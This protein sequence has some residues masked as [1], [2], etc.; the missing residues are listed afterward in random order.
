MKQNFKICADKDIRLVPYSPVQERDIVEIRCQVYN[1]SCKTDSVELI[2]CFDGLEIHKQTLEVQANSYGLAVF[3]MPMTGKAGKHQI[4]INGES[5]DLEVLKAAPALL[6]GGFIMFGPPNDRDGCDPFRDDLKKMTES[7]WENYVD[8]LY[9]MGADCIIITASA[10]YLCFMPES[11][12]NYKIVAHYPSKVYPKSDI[13]AN[14]PIDA[15]LRKAESKGMK[16]FVAV[17]NNYG[18]AGKVEELCELFERYNK[19][20]SFYGWY[21]SLELNMETFSEEQWNRL[22]VLTKAARKLSP[23]MPILTSPYRVPCAEFLEYVRRNDIFD[24][25]MPQD[26][27]GQKRLTLEESDTMHRLLLESANSVGKHLWGNCESFNFAS[28]F[29]K[30]VD[31]G[32]H[33]VPR[34]RDGGMNGE[35]GFVQQMQ[36]VRPYV[37]KIMNFM[38]SG[39]FAPT[40][41]IPKIGGD[42]AVKQYE[43]YMKYYKEQTKNN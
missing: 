31:N 40:G 30:G 4:S 5:V 26:W 6:N 8:E 18:Y 19:Y 29:N 13:V 38:F 43:D 22:A 24:I 11:G 25:I 36:T 32:G 9:K 39:F 21:F 20:K 23:V 17:G 28:V 16:V 1:E 7:D 3:S 2:F 42:A 15:L 27:V 34:F 14:D 35:A 41:F 37:E 33:L 12:E 10:Q